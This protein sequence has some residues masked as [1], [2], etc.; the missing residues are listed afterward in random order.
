MSAGRYASATEVSAVRTK[1]EIEDL[2]TRA[3]ASSYGVMSQAG[4]AMVVFEMHDRRIRIDLPLPD[5]NAEEFK[6]TNH[7]TR[8]RRSPE[9]Q[10]DAWEQACRSRWRALLL[11]V[12]AKL[13]AVAIGISTFEQEFLAH[14]MMPDGLTV[15]QHVAPRIAQAYETGDM[16]PLLPAPG[17]AD[18]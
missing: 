2:L 3:G 11:T 12:K 15:G 17:R 5:Q 1:A 6:W 16:P 18:T 7:R 10:R 9:A 14:V 4:A 13:E 8:R